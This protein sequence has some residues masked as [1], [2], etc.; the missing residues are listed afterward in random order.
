M[1][2]LSQSLREY[3]IN[4]N[5][6]EYFADRPSNTTNISATTSLTS[7]MNKDLKKK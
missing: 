4:T 7:S 2:D 1:E 3:G 5:K 6:P